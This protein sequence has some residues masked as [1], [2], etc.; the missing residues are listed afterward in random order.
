ML[1]VQKPCQTGE[2]GH[3]TDRGRRCR[4]R[5]PNGIVGR[6]RWDGK[7]AAVYNWQMIHDDRLGR[8]M[9]D[10]RISVT[11]RCNFRCPYCMPK[12]V[13]GGDYPFL[14]RGELL[15]FEEIERLARIFCNLGVQKIRITGGE[16]L[17]RRDLHRLVSMLAALDGPT[18]LM[19]T[20][21][22]VSLPEQ[23]RALRE[24]GLMRVTVSLDSLD[25]EVFKAMN[26]VGASVESVLEGIEAAAEAGLNPVKINAVIRRGINDHTVVDLARR[27]HGSGHI[28]RFIEY[29]DVGGTNGWHLDEVVTARE[30]IERIGA[31]LPLEPIDPNY[32]GEVARRWCYRDGGGEIGVIASVSDPFCSTCTRARLSPEGQFY[33]CLFASEGVDLRSLVRGGASDGRIAR[34][35]ADT[36]HH[37]EDRY[38]QIRASQ[39]LVQPR[40]EM[41]YIGG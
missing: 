7:R 30:I 34:V 40:I 10:L 16:P 20:T 39:T 6:R 41:S 11:D 2:A 9:R 28:V 25:G 4:V 13:F 3:Y 21:N 29:M 18:D 17:L 24:A 22:G 15:T 31:E 27:F 14:A 23:A 38:S 32:A 35:I 19:L 33:T 5:A 37:R 36:W 26:D 1:I 12:A 8:P